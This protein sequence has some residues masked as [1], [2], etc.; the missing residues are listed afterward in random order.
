MN[1]R[2]N[3]LV[4]AAAGWVMNGKRE[5]WNERYRTSEFQP[6]EA[7]RRCFGML[8]VPF[9][10]NRHSTSPRAPAATRCFSPNRGMMS[11]RSIYRTKR[12]Q[13]TASSST[14]I[15]F[16]QRSQS[17]AGRAATESSII[18]RGYRGSTCHRRSGHTTR[19]SS[20]CHWTMMGV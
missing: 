1:I 6:P 12:S 19:F 8:S 9:R 3:A 20:A 5:N 2:E 17:N 7:P 11:T 13:P 14:N 15:T 18:S 10:R 4:R 16:D